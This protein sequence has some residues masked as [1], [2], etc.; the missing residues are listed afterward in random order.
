MLNSH[1]K[2]AS[3]KA[4]MASG[5]AVAALM[6]GSHAFAQQAATVEEVVVTGTSIRGVAPVGSALIGVT[7]DQI[8]AIAPT[9]TK[10]LLASVP[11]LGNFGTN[12]EQSTPNRFRTSGYLANIHNLG[13]YATLTL[14]NGH[15]IAPTGTEGTYPDPSNIPT[16]AIQRTEII[17]DGASAI[18][19]SDATAGVVNFIYRKPFD[20]IEAQATYSFDGET[21]Y[22]KKNFGVLG[23]KTWDGGGIML[24]YEYSSNLSPLTSE[25]PFIALN[26]DQRSRGGRD[27][28]GVTNC[29]T[30]TIRKVQANGVPTGTTYG[31]S[32]SGFSTNQP[33]FRCPSRFIPGTLINDG[34]RNAFL[35]TVNHQVT[36]NVKVYAEVSYGHV[37]QEGIGGRPSISV[38]LPRTNPYFTAANIPPILFNDPAVTRVQI[39]RS[40]N[41]LFGYEFRNGATGTLT[42]FVSGLEIDL[43]SDWKGDLSLNLSRTRDTN[44]R[45]G[46]ELDFLNLIAA[47]N[48]TNPATALNLFGTRA[49]NN[50][51]TL[52]KIDSGSAQ[53]N[54]GQQGLQE[55][56]FKAD[57]PV[58]DLP[59][60]AM[61]AAV[62]AS[63][64]ASQSN[65]LQL[66][67]S[68]GPLSGYSGVV[69]DDHPRQQVSAAFFE[70]N[71]PLVSD[72]N[73]MPLVETLTLSVSGRYD[74]YDKY[75]GSFNPKYGI[76]YSP[77]GDLNF[78]ASYGTNFNAPN[79]GLLGGLFGQPNY[80]AN[81]NL[82]IGYGPYKGTLLTNINQYTLSGQGGGN[83]T[84]EEAKTKSFGFEWTPS[85]MGLEGLRASINWYHVD[86]TNLFF[87]VVGSELITNGNFA[88]LAEFFPTPERMAEI[89]RLYPSSGAITVANFEYVPHTEAVNLGT[90]IYEGI[91]YDISYRFST[92]N[93]GNFQL[94]VT[95]AQQLKFDQQVLPGQAFENRINTNDA[96]KWKARVNAGWNIGNFTTSVFYNYTGSYINTAS[97]IVPR[98]EVSPFKTVDLTMAY[99]FPETGVSFLKGISLQ[100][101]VSNL[102]DK[103]PPFFDNGDGYN[104]S[105]A[106]PYPRAYDLTLRAKF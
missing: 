98:Q 106:S 80:N 83:L 21:R 35:M 90:R 41:E 34:E 50:P 95:A 65:Q 37:E 94:G 61:R 25:I 3:L 101:R 1:T 22:E 100:G 93:I 71:V 57:G 58:M 46:S 5:A 26:G 24:A 43:G 49:Q 17:A 52:A 66:A 40:G 7:R 74:Y 30:P 2:F 92:E 91:D 103:D 4:A 12:A 78:H 31:S 85:Y 97:V 84:P 18:Y 32:A 96:V 55:L 67:G 75:G 60:G 72:S 69:R 68:R 10:D 82:V 63:F 13:I 9:N 33:D 20:G 51:A 79:V 28:R 39:A 105:W 44:G 27:T 38:L 87:K 54:W 99:D 23:G 42:N 6:A 81:P 8:Q 11:A 77:G 73:A 64:R 102:F 19:G 29:L 53:L 59:G 16:I 88:S 47:A 62:G 86:Y 56:A 14:V 45:P 104:G 48:D 89:I 76:V 15:R 36:D 70:L